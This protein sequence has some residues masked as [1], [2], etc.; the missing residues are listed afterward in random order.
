MRRIPFNVDGAERSRGADVFAPSAADA[1]F[2]V[3]L[4]DRQRSL[5]WNHVERLSRAV[6]GTRAATRVLRVDDAVV[7]NEDD[8]PHLD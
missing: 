5:I 2:D 7:L 4:G 8:V 3:D 1:K 6:F